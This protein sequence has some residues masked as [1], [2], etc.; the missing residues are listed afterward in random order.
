MGKKQEESNVSD[1]IRLEL[2][3]RECKIFRSQV[4]LFYTQYGD[5]IYIGVKG[6]SDLHGHRADGKAFYIETKTPIGKAKPEQIKFID[7]MKKS[8]AIAGFAHSVEEAIN[9]VFPKKEEQ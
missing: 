7:A 4:G 5:M 3:K 6:Q 8:G 1:A 9:I 2:C